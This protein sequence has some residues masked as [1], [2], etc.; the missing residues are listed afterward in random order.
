MCCKCLLVL[1]SLAN[2][3]NASFLHLVVVLVG[4]YFI[5]NELTALSCKHLHT[6]SDIDNN[7]DDV[8]LYNG[9]SD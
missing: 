5:R 2:N 7:D 1:L 9:V 3:N 8:L 4:P 6:A